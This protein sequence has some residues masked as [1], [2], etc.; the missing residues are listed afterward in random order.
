MRNYLLFSFFLPLFFF[1]VTDKMM[2]WTV[3]V[4]KWRP[5][6]PS[7]NLAVSSE[8]CPNCYVSFVYVVVSICP[9]YLKLCVTIFFYGKKKRLML[10]AMVL[11]KLVKWI[12]FVDK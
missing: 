11:L 8:Y 5:L 6:S 10:A 3:Q 7:H 1:F 4:T 9:F 2:V 12:G